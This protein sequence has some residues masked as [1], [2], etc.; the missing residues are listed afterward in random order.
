[1]FDFLY[2]SLTQKLWGIWQNFFHQTK[3]LGPLPTK[4]THFKLS[5]L[6]KP[7][8]STL[9]KVNVEKFPTQEISLKQKARY[10]PI[11]KA[12]LKVMETNQPSSD[13]LNHLLNLTKSQSIDFG[14]Y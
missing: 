12:L 10:N 14:I 6:V 3:K 1:M 7:T 9:N 4:V 11:I 5:T 13:D 8:T 2:L